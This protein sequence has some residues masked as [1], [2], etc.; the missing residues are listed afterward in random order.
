M[1]LF[2][3]TCSHARVRILDDHHLHPL[4]TSY[5]QLIWLTDLP[6]PDVKGLGLTSF[7]LR[8]D[9]TA[10]RVIVDTEDAVRW[11]E[12]A[13]DHKVPL[14]IRLALDHIDGAMPLRWWVSEKSIPIRVIEPTRKD[15]RW[16]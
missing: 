16:Q 10:W 11:T 9:R 12:W 6:E 14:D 15:P 2:H 4:S 8:C 13:H 3:Y 5:Q 7:M 1:K